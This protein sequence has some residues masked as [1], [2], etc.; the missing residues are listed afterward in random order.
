[1]WTWKDIKGNILIYNRGRRETNQIVQA[2]LGSED[3]KN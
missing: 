3:Y 1:M 2:L